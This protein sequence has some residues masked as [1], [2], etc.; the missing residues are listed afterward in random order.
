MN[1]SEYINQLF[2]YNNVL[3]Y[4]PY[5]GNIVYI[6][7]GYMDSL[8]SKQDQ[9][10]FVLLKKDR[11]MGWIVIDQSMMDSVNAFKSRSEEAV[12]FHA[13]LNDSLTWVSEQGVIHFIQQK[14]MNNEYPQFN[15][16]LITLKDTSMQDWNAIMLYHVLLNVKPNH[17]LLAHSLNSYS[18]MAHGVLTTYYDISKLFN[19]LCDIA[20]QWV[21]GTSFIDI[22]FHLFTNRGHRRLY[23]HDIKDYHEFLVHISGCLGQPQ[24]EEKMIQFIENFI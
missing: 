12:L 6:S 1:N 16:E 14:L 13:S 11:Y 15:K 4:L 24:Q 20:I 2:D 22:R 19:T 3:E 17:V 5:Y 7:H 18:H 21:A 8:T 9:P 23:L 10:Y